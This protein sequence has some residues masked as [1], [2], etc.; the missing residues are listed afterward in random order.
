MTK[1]STISAN[2]HTTARLMPPMTVV[3]KSDGAVTATPMNPP[4][5]AMYRDS[6]AQRFQSR[7]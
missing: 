3:A 7:R 4:Y 6:S 5:A 2:P 1:A